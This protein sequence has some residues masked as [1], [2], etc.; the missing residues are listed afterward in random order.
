MRAAAGSLP[1]CLPVGRRLPALPSARLLCR[2]LATER[3]RTQLRLAVWSEGKAKGLPGLLAYD[4]GAKG[5]T[6][7]RGRGRGHTRTYARTQ[8]THTHTAHTRQSGDGAAAGLG[9]NK[10]VRSN[11]GADQIVPL[12]SILRLLI[13]CVSA[14][15]PKRRSP[16][17][18]PVLQRQHGRNA[19]SAAV[20]G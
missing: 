16:P 13:G 6:G 15:P 8:H 4:S 20:R 10:N 5:H 9:D 17:P 14:R 7:E 11:E 12:P 19:K 1:A 18:A 3:K 2:L